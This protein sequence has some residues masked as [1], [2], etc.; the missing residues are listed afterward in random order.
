GHLGGT[1][2][3]IDANPRPHP[4]RRAARLA[5]RRP[6]PARPRARGAGPDQ[7]PGLRHR[8]GHPDRLDRPRRPRPDDPPAGRRGPRKRERGAPGRHRPQP[9]RHAQLGPAARRLLPGSSRGHA[10]LHLRFRPGRGPGRRADRRLDRLQRGLH[11]LAI[12][13][14]ARRPP[15]DRAALVGGGRGGDR[16][17][18]QRG[19]GVVPDP[20]G[21]ADRVGR[22]RRRRAA[23]PDRRADLARGAGGRGWLRPGLPGRRPARRPAD[24][25]R[26]RVHRPRRRDAGL[27]PAD[28]RGRP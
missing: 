14:Q 16:L 2:G 25:G 13:P 22:P 21:P 3:T 9:R 10:P 24:R 1:V 20:D 15:A 6:P 5:R 11:P 4:P 23:R 26:D 7:R 18:R 12:A 8:R 19:G 17:R 27:V 28:G